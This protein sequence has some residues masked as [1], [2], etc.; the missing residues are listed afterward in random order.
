METPP[1]LQACGAPVPDDARMTTTSIE[2]IRSGSAA[3][4]TSETW[5]AARA[6]V[7][8]MTPFLVG[9]LP[10][11]LAIGVAAGASPLDDLVGWATGP[12][13]FSGSAQLSAIE[14]LGSGVGA[15][16][17]VL[18]LLLLNAR[19]ALY[20]AALAPK[21]ACQPRW[22]RWLAPYFIVDP[23]VA[24]ATDESAEGCG[25]R[26]YRWYYLGAAVSLWLMW[27]TAI[28]AGVLVGPIVDASWSLDFAAPLC[29]VAMLTAKLRD[30]RSRTAGVVAGAVAIAAVA[31]PP[32]ATTALAMVG[33]A[34]AAAAI[35][36][37]TP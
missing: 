15:V 33:G 26:W 13:L 31:M 3:E 22:F 34:I 23:V 19:L 32:G 6:G 10:F 25:A 2:H 30:R 17:V 9:L 37:S 4:T 5:C 7:R 29:L 14:M 16:T 11:A 27:V 8:A 28:T 35:E 18:S 12:I 20:G 1:G 36:R 24:V 21:L